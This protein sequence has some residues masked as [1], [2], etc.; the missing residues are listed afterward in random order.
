MANERYKIIKLMEHKEWLKDAPIKI[1]K[2]QLLF[3]TQKNTTLLQIKMFNLSSKYIKSVFLDLVCYNNENN[4][5]EELTDVAY[6]MIEAEPQTVFGDKKPILL[7]SLQVESVE[8]IISKVIFLDGSVWNNN[9]REKGILLEEQK[10][11]D[12]NNT[13]YEQIKR[14]FTGTNIDPFYWFENNEDYW[15]CTCG[16]TNGISALKCGYCGI[17][18]SWIEKHL[19]K[20]YLLEMDKKYHEAL[21]LQKRQEEES[22]QKLAEEALIIKKQKEDFIAEENKNR[23]KFISSGLIVLSSFIIVI[24]AIKGYEKVISPMITYRNAMLF[25]NNKDYDK[26]VEVFSNMQGYKNSEDMITKSIY[27]NGIKLLE[28]S[29]YESSLEQFK[30]V[31]EFEDASKYIIECHY[32]IGKELMRNNKWQEAMDHLTISKDYED[33]YNKIQECYFQIANN[34]IL[35]KKWEDALNTY[36]KIDA[37]AIKEDLNAAISEAYYQYG[38]YYATNQLWDKALDCMIQAISNGEYKDAKSLIDVYNNNIKENEL[39]AQYDEAI[40]FEADGRLDLA[41]NTYKTLSANYKDCGERMNRI[42]GYI[43]LCGNYEGEIEYNAR[44]M[45]DSGYKAFITKAEVTITFENDIPIINILITS[46]K[47]S[48]E[49]YIGK[50]QN[51]PITYVKD[52]SS[53]FSSSKTVFRFTKG[54][55]YRDWYLDKDSHVSTILKFKKL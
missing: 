37:D 22:K 33:S 26:A 54:I 44:T 24:G 40:G 4:N 39:L 47:N 29:E 50:L 23:K 46:Y 28:S 52:Y 55:L 12:H 5:V 18:K 41:Y 6:L 20:E 49:R 15:R 1:E 21:L 11:I 34:Y 16:Q 38:L 35:D 25:Y 7:K 3:D 45:K 19:E 43:N 14:E 31:E 48:G 36:K 51:M 8:I 42:S 32:N 27:Q 30:R 13:L 53:G 10:I 2:S 17:E 9:D